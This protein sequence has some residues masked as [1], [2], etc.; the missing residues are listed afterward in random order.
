MALTF[1]PILDILPKPQRTLWDELAAIP[2]E[3]VLYGGTA[4]ALQL[5]HRQS[6]DFDF[7]AD[8]PID[9]F[10]LEAAVPFMAGARII[11]RDKN[12]LTGIIDRGGPVA[13]SF[14]GLPALRRL[15]P[16]LISPDNGIKIASLLDLAGMKVSVVQAR[17][18]AKDYLDLDAL[19]TRAGIDLPTALAA[20]REIYGKSFNPQITLKALSY[21]HDGNLDQLPEETKRRLAFA[22]RDVDLDSLPAVGDSSDQSAH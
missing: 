5:A 6:I 15:A 16:A 20:G 4:I 19:M 11:N 10:R 13:I 21:Y 9:P 17:A 7:F 14:F 1:K 22:A 3:F 2:G 18:E 12:T 8:Q